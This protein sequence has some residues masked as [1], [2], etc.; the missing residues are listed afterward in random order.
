VI[1]ASGALAAAAL[2]DWS[3]PFRV[4]SP[5]TLDILP[6]K[7]SISAADQAA[8]A[9]AVQDEDNAARSSAFAVMRLANGRL[10]RTWRVPDS[11]E[12]LDL[13]FV[14]DSLEL[15]TGTSQARPCC[16]TVGVATIAH[17]SIR[18]PQTIVRGLTGATLGRLVALPRGGLLAAVATGRGIWVTQANRGHRFGAARQLAAAGSQPRALV[19]TNLPDGGG[20]VAWAA[21]ERQAPARTIWVAYGSPRNAPAHRRVALRVAP[22]HEIDELAIAAGKRAPVLAW[23]ESWFDSR[24]RYHSQP[25]V[26]AL[27]AAPRPRYLAVAGQLASDL[28]VAGNQAGDQVVAWNSCTADGACT[29]RSSQRR[30]RGGF[31]APQ[32]VAAVD[33][34]QTPAVAVGSGG[35]AL[36]GWIAHGHVFAATR[37]R[38]S[39]AFGRIREVSATSF[40]SDLALAFGPAGRALAAWTQGTFEPSVVGAAWRQ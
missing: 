4:S 24:G 23:I 3:R 31:G 20:I 25:A 13:A 26:A 30:A 2:S 33:P 21:D 38:R 17:S 14:G 5:R 15:L 7:L 18:R 6:T 8:I 35:Q 37:V 34:S 11:Q 16:T 28:A 19:A 12:V 40:A 29:L 10:L 36:V 9:Y 32:R 27:S 39:G 1:A 22:G